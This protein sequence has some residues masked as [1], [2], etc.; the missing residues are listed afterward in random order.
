MRDEELVLEILS[1]IHDATKRVMKR[2][3]PIHCAADFTDSESGM[4]KL[5][6]I[7]MQLVAIGEGL[8]NVDSMT[9]K[10]LLVQYPQIEWKKVKGMRDII[11]HHYFDVDAEAIFDVCTNHI[12]PPAD[13]LDIIIRDIS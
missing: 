9:D 1:Q 7:C 11:S 2:F 13:T 6:A 4:E 12:R 3:E 5:D 10:K 8:K